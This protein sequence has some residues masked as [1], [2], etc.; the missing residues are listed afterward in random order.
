[1]YIVTI[2]Y[3]QVIS[4]TCN[5]IVYNLHIIKIRGNKMTIYHLNQRCSQMESPLDTRWQLT[6]VVCVVFQ[7]GAPAPA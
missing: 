5:H 3:L 4:M 2:L 1:M 6:S 7:N